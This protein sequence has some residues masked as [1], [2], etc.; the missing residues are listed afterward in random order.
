V[1][2]GLGI[3]FRPLGQ[4]AC[5]S[6]GWNRC[7]L[8]STSLHSRVGWHSLPRDICDF[9]TT[10]YLTHLR[11]SIWLRSPSPVSTGR[12]EHYSS[13]SHRGRTP[14][15]C[16]RCRCARYR[17]IP[18]MSCPRGNP[19]NDTGNSHNTC[20]PFGR[21]I[22]S[23]GRGTCAARS[24]TILQLWPLDRGFCSTG[25]NAAGRSCQLATAAF[26]YSP[27]YGRYG[28]ERLLSRKCSD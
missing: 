14:H 20:L 8:C 22:C 6:R 2:C 24:T 17:T 19:P 21:G 18:D 3:G 4:R 12:Y 5:G 27:R 11:S 15:T 26:W 23:W 28:Q 7:E 13:R 10:G 1:R 9:R 16:I 25:T